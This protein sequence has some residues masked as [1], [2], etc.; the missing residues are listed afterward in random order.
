M[1]FLPQIAATLLGLLFIAFSSMVIFNLAPT[2]PAPPEGS[3]AAHF[4]AAF[5]PTGYL[6]FIKWCEFIGGI[7]VII[8]KTRNIGLLVLTPIIVNIVAFHVFITNGADVFSPVIL[9][10]EALT[11]FLFWSERRRFLGLIR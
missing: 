11:L 9:A 10:I 3:P 6:H 1:R 7:L 5:A 2:P 8:P 4:M